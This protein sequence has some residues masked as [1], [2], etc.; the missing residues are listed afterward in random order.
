MSVERIYQHVW[1][2][3]KQG[4]EL[5]PFLAEQRKKIPKA[6]GQKGQIV[7][8]VSIENRPAMVEN[9]E[10]FGDLEIDT[11]IGKDQLYMIIF[12]K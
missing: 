3:K 6:R 5:V 4:G 2:D 11:I 12:Y 7:G 9:R 8:R 1:A 10:R